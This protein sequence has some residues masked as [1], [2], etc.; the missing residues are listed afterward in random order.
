MLKAMSDLLKEL[1]K[2]LTTMINVGGSCGHRVNALKQ[3]GH[4]ASNYLI[5]AADAAADRATTWEVRN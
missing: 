4:D 1:A 3:Q 5:V 2:A